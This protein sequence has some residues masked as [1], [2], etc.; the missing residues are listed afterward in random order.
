MI[1]NLIQQGFIL[2]TKGFYK[3]AIESFYKALEHD[4]SS[5][6]LLMEISECYFLMGDEKQAL[7]YI[8]KIL[9]KNPTHIETLKLLKQIFIN[10]K[11]WR[12]AEET[13]KNIF[14]ISNNQNDLLEV[15]KLLNMQSLYEKVLE[16]QVDDNNEILY[17]RA[18]ACLHLNQLD[19]AESVINKALEQNYSTKNLL[20]KCKI[21]YKMN[22]K[23]ECVDLFK[24]IQ[25]DKSNSDAL[26]FA[27]L[28]K[29]YEC[30]FKKALEYFIEA[31]KISPHNSE[32]FYNCAS[33]YFKMGEIQY[34]KKYYNLAISLD[35]ENVNYHFALAN[36][37]YSEKHYK[38]ALE[39][40][41]SELFEARL[42][43]SIILYDSGYLVIAKRELDKLA[44]EQPENELIINYQ[45][46]IKEELSI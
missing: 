40:L 1:K 11:A 9:D 23:D 26:N 15:L 41:N 33:T 25:I 30:E 22:K 3:H 16:Y 7:K 17:E 13:T 44:K 19:E 2:K 4:H 35:P 37:Y 8:E 20:L 5:I 34:A 24:Q 12:E 43:K 31:T 27:G 32:Y 45:N 46:L 14:Y 6:E 39:E 21:L 29:Q 10:K 28:V 36:L 18:F 42:L 38:R